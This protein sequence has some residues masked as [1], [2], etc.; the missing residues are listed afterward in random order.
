MIVQAVIFLFVFT[1]FALAQ[2]Q[3]FPGAFG[4]GATTRGGRGRPCVRYVQN[5]ADT[6]PDSLRHVL[7]AVEA[8]GG[9]CNVLFNVT[10]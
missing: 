9:N 4:H 6:G 3:A 1:A 5:R 10:G 8:Q 2:K 7:G